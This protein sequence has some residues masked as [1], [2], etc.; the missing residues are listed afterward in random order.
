MEPQ[1]Q[2]L[3][4][5]AK[6]F[7]MFRPL[8]RMLPSEWANQFRYLSPESASNPGK[9]STALT[10]YAIAPMDSVVDVTST[11]TVLM[12]A[13]QLSKTETINNIIGYF[14]AIEPAPIL[15]VQPTIDLAEAWSKERFSPMIRDTPALSDRVSE[16]K[17]RTSS[18]TILQKSFPGGNIAMAGA[19]AASG[20]A[21]RPRRVVLLD[22]VD[23][24]PASAGTEGDPC[25]LAIRRTETFHNP[26][27]F[28]TSTPTIKD[29]SRVES[30]YLQSDQSH[31]VCKCPKCGFSQVLN[32]SQIRWTEEDGSDAYY[33]CAGCKTPLD[34]SDRMK[35]VRFGKWVADYPKKTKRGFH[36]NG[37]A[38][39]FPHKRGFKN[40]LHQ[41][42]AEYLDSKAKG[43]ESLKTWTNTFLAETY[44]DESEAVA[45]EPLLARRE[46]WG[47]FPREAYIITAGV[48]IQGDRVEIEF[49]GWG[50][51]EESW[52]LDYLM[53]MGDFNNLAIQQEVE[54]ALRIRAKITWTN[55]LRFANYSA[56]KISRRKLA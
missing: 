17:S 26:V 50:T 28:I 12:W 38:S 7:D 51:S 24:Y 13:S 44:E 22:E 31:W 33:E 46:N 42:V 36:L 27:V 56:W 34:D 29:R 18:N 3:E 41:M 9:Y 1:S 39:L 8:P 37:I 20:L 14:I 5:T 25:S 11:G 48:D 49:V 10:P 2:T 45:W 43:K 53:I 52:S 19:N 23:R 55:K 40:R 21:S 6:W 16:Q 47:G 15:M 4:I 35:M 30:E 54:E 32:W